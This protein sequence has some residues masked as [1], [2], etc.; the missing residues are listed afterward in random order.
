MNALS[1][2]PTSAARRHDR[3]EDQL[4]ELLG[5][6]RKLRPSWQDPRKFFEG[7]SDLIDGLRRL[8][9]DGATLPPLP[10]PGALPLPQLPLPQPQLPAPRRRAPV[11]TPRATPAPTPA[12]PDLLLI[13]PP[14]RHLLLLALATAPTRTRPQPRSFQHR[15]EV[16]CAAV[17]EKAPVLTLTLSAAEADWIARQ[18]RHRKCGGYQR[19][20]SAIFSNLHPAFSNIRAIPRRPP[21]QRK[22]RGQRRLPGGEVHAA[23]AAP[24]DRVEAPGRP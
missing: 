8:L 1:P 12:R 3:V 13:L 21:S 22:K 5:I 24:G 6:A 10:A 9:A 14:E 2:T 7:Q 15:A 17:D 11:P 18:I 23:Q 20:L 19:K 16:W 4:Q